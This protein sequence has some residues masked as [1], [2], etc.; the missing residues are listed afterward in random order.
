MK[1]HADDIF[2]HLE[3]IGIGVSGGKDS[4]AL[5]IWAIENFPNSKIYPIFA[6]TGWEHPDTYDYLYY[7]ED[8]LGVHVYRVK[9][10]KYA[11]MID[12]IRQKKMFPG[13]RRRI[14]TYYLKIEPIRDFL[15]ENNIKVHMQGTRKR[16]SLTRKKMYS[17]Y[18]PSEYYPASIFSAY[19]TQQMDIYFRFPLL[20]W[21]GREV[22]KYLKKHNIKLNPLYQKGFR[23]V[24]CYPCL[25]SYKDIKLAALDGD[26]GKERVEK[27][28]ELE[29]ELNEIGFQTRIL[30]NAKQNKMIS[31]LLTQQVLEVIP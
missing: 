12:L 23:R 13:P 18:S 31:G 25:L 6:D 16:E 19:Y 26:V 14:C 22:L 10:K 21:D 7:L 20:E 29:H 5:L 2:S 15:I 4:T 1:I 9:S 17:K 30:V 3:K 8:T 27:L 11:D 28:L 24:G